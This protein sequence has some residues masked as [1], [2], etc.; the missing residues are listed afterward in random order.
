M[1]PL[2]TAGVILVVGFVYLSLEPPPT[3]KHDWRSYRRPRCRQFVVAV[4]AVTELRSV[5][6]HVQLG[7]GAKYC[8]QRVCLSVCL[9]ACLFVCL[10]AYLKNTRRNFTKFSVD[11]TSVRGWSSSDNNTIFYVLPILWITSRFTKK[12]FSEWTRI[13]DDVYI[14]PSK[15][16][17]GTVRDVCRLRL[18]LVTLILVGMQAV[19]GSKRC[20][21][22]ILQLLTEDVG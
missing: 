21:D 20:S 5:N 2:N 13:K 6:L 11:V 4:T 3:V 1:F 7:T 9:S 14:S 16:S 18:H 22:K 19:I 12:K 17:G 8:N 10:L 15:P